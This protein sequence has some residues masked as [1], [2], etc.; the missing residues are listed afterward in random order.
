MTSEDSGVEVEADR[1]GVANY[2]GAKGDIQ[3]LW[4]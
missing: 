4:N 1:D 2:I 3:P